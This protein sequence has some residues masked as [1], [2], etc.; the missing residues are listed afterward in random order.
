MTI[1]EKA[2]ELGMMIAES[3]EFINLEKA[4][5][6]QN[7]DEEAQ[8][9]IA[10]FTAKRDELTRKITSPDVT[11]ETMKEVQEQ[12]DEEYKILTSNSNIAAYLEATGKFQNMMNEVNSILSFYINGPQESNC[13]GSCSTCGGCH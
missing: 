1:A 12:M 6:A 10:A 11:E 5:I 9:L 2:K 13:T 7:A 8:K 4:E 3:E